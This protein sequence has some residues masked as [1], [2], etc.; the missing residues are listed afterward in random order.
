MVAFAVP[1]TAQEGT[2]R[3]QP[4]DV[5]RIQIYNDQ[6]IAALVPVGRDG[7]ISAP[8]IGIVRAQGKTTAELEADLREEYI[9]KLRLRDPIVSVTMEK[10]R[11]VRASVGG[12]VN[13]A[14]TFEVR[15][16][17]TLLS[18]LN[19]GGGTVVDRADLRRAT[20]RHAGSPELIPIDLY[21]MLI[22]G[23]TSQN[24]TVQDGDELIVPEET[25]LRVIVAGNV[26]APGTYP[27]K[28]PM[29]AYDAISLARG[30]VAYR[31]KLSKTLII[32]EQPG[33]PGN[34]LRME[35][36]LVKFVR[37]GDSTQNVALMPGDI[38]WVPDSGNLDFTQ[39][40]AVANILYILDRAG[41]RI[42]NAN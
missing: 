33:Q 19:M 4:E 25:K 37:R 36:D 7:N 17:D 31:S 6:Q 21:A 20:L 11:P 39:V 35:V 5:I 10:Y 3:L 40:N 22:R 38:V 13:R 34:Y 23:D 42:L 24:Y 18:L 32:R 14:G 28:E 30:P 16:G 1:A 2:Y 27:Y 26:T 29:T 41:I 8:F 9:K 15:P 12:F